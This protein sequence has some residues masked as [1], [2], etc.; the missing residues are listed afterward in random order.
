[1]PN[2]W[3][4]RAGAGGKCIEDFE[5]GY[6]AIGWTDMGDI[7]QLKSTDDIRAKYIEVYGNE[8]PS[9]TSNTVLMLAKFRDVI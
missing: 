8:K 4:I 5:K 9:R 2:N 6:A 3:M 1:M 7:S